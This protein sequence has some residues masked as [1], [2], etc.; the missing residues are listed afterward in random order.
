MTQTNFK[1][2]NQI[3]KGIMSHLPSSDDQDLNKESNK[4]SMYSGAKCHTDTVVVLPKPQNIGKL[5]FK[6]NLRIC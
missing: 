6:K 5:K 4:W 1:Y 2:A 3:L